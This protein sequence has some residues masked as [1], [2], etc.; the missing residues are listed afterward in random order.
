[1][2]S[3]GKVDDSVDERSSKPLDRIASCDLLPP[4]NPFLITDDGFLQ[5]RITTPSS[6]L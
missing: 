3:G 5:T 6:A 4:G 1:V 2:L